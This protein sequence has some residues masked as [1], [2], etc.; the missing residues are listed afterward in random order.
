MKDHL[1]MEFS[2]VIPSRNRPENLMVCLESIVRMF[3]LTSISYEMIIV[4]DGSNLNVRKHYI[5][6]SEQYNTK[7]LNSRGSGPSAARN[8]GAITAQGEWIYFIDDDVIMDE[9]SIQWWPTQNRTEGAGYQGITRVHKS[10]NW[11][12]IRAST[13][14]FV[15]GFGSG[16]I[17]Y[18][19]DLFLKLGGFD[20]AYFLK[21]FGIHFRE[22]T[23]LGLRFVRNGYN[24]PVVDQMTANHPA[25][26]SRDPLFLLKDARKYFFEPYFKRRNPEASSW[27]GSPFVKGR[28]GTYQLRGSISI[29]FVSLLPLVNYL[30]PLVPGILLFLYFVL[31]LIIFRSLTLT[32]SFWGYAPLILIFYPIIHGFSYLIGFIFGPR[33]PRLI[34]K[35]C[36]ET[37]SGS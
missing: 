17:I 35:V 13:A 26:D 5:E 19:R 12:H 30:W 36:R 11:S 31:S 23:D 8:L 37:N 34:N 7:L 10:P 27:I 4:D 33:G 14:D 25:H 20:E 28:L 18:R 24:L 29:L 9:K 16:N 21:S 6:L 2:V 22:D 15:D 32:P 1:L 3:A